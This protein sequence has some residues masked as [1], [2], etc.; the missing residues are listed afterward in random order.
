MSC[1][2]HILAKCN[3]QLY[4]TTLVGTCTPLKNWQENVIESSFL[5][6]PLRDISYFGELEFSSTATIVGNLPHVQEELQQTTYCNA[7]LGL[8]LHPAG[9]SSCSCRKKREVIIFRA[10]QKPSRMKQGATYLQLVVS[11]VCRL[12][13]LLVPP[14]PKGTVLYNWR[15][16]II[17]HKEHTSMLY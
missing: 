5:S 15:L 9:V 6:N 16:W 4:R 12:T 10:V 1:R 13:V 17:L 11:R 8:A 3:Q 2:S 14:V 7:I